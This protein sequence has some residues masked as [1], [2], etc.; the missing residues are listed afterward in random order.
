MIGGT[1]DSNFVGYNVGRL[2]LLE[3][4]LKFMKPAKEH[5]KVL[6][7]IREIQK[8]KHLEQ[9]IGPVKPMVM[10]NLMNQKKLVRKNT[11]Q[12][13]SQMLIDK[14]KSVG[15]EQFRGIAAKPDAFLEKVYWQ[16]KQRKPIKTNI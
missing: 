15:V 16:S 14:Q 6:D 7:M 4:N 12:R 10:D 2:D 13:L 3:E 5:S 8:K 11:E 9:K 1:N